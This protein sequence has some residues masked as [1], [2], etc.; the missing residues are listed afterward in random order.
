MT[1]PPLK[2]AK[3]PLPEFVPTARAQDAPLSI[4]RISDHPP[5]TC[6]QLKFNTPGGE[7]ARSRSWLFGRFREVHSRTH[8]ALP[9]QEFEQKPKT[10]TRWLEQTSGP[11]P[12]V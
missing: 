12:E 10:P 11:F 8:P 3:Q 9:I 4:L 1:F 6:R 5:L 7:S 2:Q